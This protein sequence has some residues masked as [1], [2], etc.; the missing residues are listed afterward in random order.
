[1]S[2]LPASQGGNAKKPPSPGTRPSTRQAESRLPGSA[3]ERS[4]HDASCSSA[5]TPSQS[6]VER[7]GPMHG[8]SSEKPQRPWTRLSSKAAESRLPGWI[9]ERD[10]SE[11]GSSSGSRGRQ[12][13]FEGLDPGYKP[14]GTAPMQRE[15]DTVPTA[16]SGIPHRHRSQENDESRQSQA[17]ANLSIRNV[18]VAAEDDQ[19]VPGVVPYVD[20]HY[21]IVLSS[22]V[23]EDEQLVPRAASDAGG[24]SDTPMEAHI[25]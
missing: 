17:Q 1:M 2:K 12:N 9:S 15:T 13:P 5:T 23:E 24:G 19:V 21:Q 14:S 8:G 18:E 20:E 3:S 4:R 25:A 16:V 7:L 11:A 22:A 6:S 10:Q